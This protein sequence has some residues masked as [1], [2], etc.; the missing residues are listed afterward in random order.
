MGQVGC[1]W[2][3][4][5]LYRMKLRGLFSLP[6]APYSDSFL[7]GCCCACALSQ[8]YRELMNRGIDPSMGWEANVEKWNRDGVTLPIAAD[9]MHR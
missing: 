9:G 6:E 7:H 1:Q 4:G 3:Y 8:E 5:S 2:L